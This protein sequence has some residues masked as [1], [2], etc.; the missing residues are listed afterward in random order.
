MFAASGKFAEAE[1]DFK[2]AEELLSK[3][4]GPL[5]QVIYLSILLQANE[6]FAEVDRPLLFP[7]EL[8]LEVLSKIPADTFDPLFWEEWTRRTQGDLSVDP[9]KAFPY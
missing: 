7:R 5:I 9:Q 4:E 6:L 3:A 8:Q 2:K 1:T